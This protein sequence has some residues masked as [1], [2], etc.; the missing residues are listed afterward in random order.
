MQF[1]K[2]VGTACTSFA[3]TNIDD[4]FVLVT[5]FAEASTSTTLTPRKITLGQYIGFTVIIVISMVGFGASLA[6][7]SEPIG[8]LGLL[9]ILLGIWKLFDDIIFPAEEE[10][11]DKTSIAA[12]KTTLKVALVTLMNGGDN[13]GTYIPLFSQTKGAEIAVYVVIY[14]ILVG[15]WCLAAF[16]VLRQKHV[17]AIIQKYVSYLIPVLYVGL[18]VYIIIKSSCYPWSIERIDDLHSAHPGTAIM[19]SVTVFLVLVSIGAMI[20]IKLSQRTTSPVLDVDMAP[21]VAPS[22]TADRSAED[23]HE[24]GEHLPSVAGEE[25]GD[26]PREVRRQAT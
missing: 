21:E 4:L 26:Q 25:Q 12:M 10:E 5:F 7:P 9:P 1:G 16:L 6:L 3:I 8:F 24:P 13:I 11:S 23:A 14:Y 15:V 20:W 22:P 19:A 18:G 17:L 2:A